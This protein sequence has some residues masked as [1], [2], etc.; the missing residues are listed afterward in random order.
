[1]TL[2]SAVLHR[3]EGGVRFDRVGAFGGRAASD[4]TA[5]GAIGDGAA[6]YFAVLGT[7]GSRAASDAIVVGAFGGREI[8]RDN[9]HS[10][11][12]SPKSIPS[13]GRRQIR[14]K[15]AEHATKI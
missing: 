10:P 2:Y 11:K 8:P 15:S 4:F 3:R 13:L 12:S 5:V 14:S 7:F 6:V 1:M 9:R